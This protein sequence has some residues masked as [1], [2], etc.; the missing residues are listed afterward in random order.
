MHEPA[1]LIHVDGV[2]TDTDRISA[3]LP[4]DLLE[5]VRK[6]VRILALLLLAAFASDLVIWAGAVIWAALTGK[7]LPA[8]FYDPRTFLWLDRGQGA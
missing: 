4:S 3:A 1:T 8:E 6:R 2:P 5:Q 7:V